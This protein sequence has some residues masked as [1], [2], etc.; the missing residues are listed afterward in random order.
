METGGLEPTCVNYSKQDGSAENEEE[1]QDSSEDA[2]VNLE[3]KGTGTEQKPGK[4]AVSEDLPTEGV[5]EDVAKAGAMAT[6]VNLG[7]EQGDL[8]ESASKQRDASCDKP[9]VPMEIV[10]SSWAPESGVIEFSLNADTEDKAGSVFHI[11][12]DQPATTAQTRNQDSTITSAS[13]QPPRDSAIAVDSLTGQDATAEAARR[14][15]VEQPKQA[16]VELREVPPNCPTWATRLKDCEEIGNSYRGYVESEVELEFLL[17]YHRQQTGTTWG[18]RQS[19]STARESK[20]LMWKSNYVPYDGIPFLNLGSR[21]IVME[22]QY[23]PRRKG[24]PHKRASESPK[25]ASKEACTCP[26]RIYVKK[27]RKF[28]DFQVEVSLEADKMTLKR[29]M[30]KV[31]QVMKEV[32]VDEIPGVERYYVQLPTNAAHQYHRTPEYQ[33]KKDP[34]NFDATARSRLHPELCDKIQEL[35]ANGEINAYI[36]RQILRAHVIR[37]MFSGASIP[38]KHNLFYFPTINDIK[39]HVLLAI[40][41]IERGELEAIVPITI[42]DARAITEPPPSSLTSAQMSFG[43]QL[44]DSAEDQ[45]DDSKISPQTQSVTVTLTQNAD[46]GG[47]FIS[48]V[49]TQLS[50]GTTFISDSLTPET[51]RLLS[52]INQH[53]QEVHGSDED[54]LCMHQIVSSEQEEMDQSDSLL[55]EPKSITSGLNQSEEEI[56][57]QKNDPT[58]NSQ[59]DALM[60]LTVDASSE[61]GHNQ[62]DRLLPAED[63]TAQSDALLEAAHSTLGQSEGL[64]DDTTTVGAIGQSK[65]LLDTDPTAIDQSG[66]LLHSSDEI[67]QSDTDLGSSGSLEARALLSDIEQDA[68]VSKRARFEV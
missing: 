25:K 1:M 63:N 15:G 51:A 9:V 4:N 61:D 67:N 43:N 47:S 48:Q 66:A 18:T 7:D 41:A 10:K 49:E 55:E 19:P 24:G 45:E 40:A 5:T 12:I 21:A 42:T 6:E 11:V 57:V 30:D 32:G 27:V 62:S 2:K 58:L 54:A 3:V 36:I 13:A 52:Q 14:S 64:L 35:V 23:G 59:S 31:F 38:E 53:C 65:H 39:N 44:W 28:P 34:V 33:I 26:A 29:Q 68:P 16:V 8:E 50:D 56:D 46:E 20:R 60:G 37:T 22:C 17:T